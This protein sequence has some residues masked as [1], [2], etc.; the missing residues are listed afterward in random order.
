MAEVREPV[1]GVTP[2]VQ[3]AEESQAGSEGTPARRIF[4]FDLHGDSEQLG[5]KLEPQ[6]AAMQVLVI[7]HVEAPAGN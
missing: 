5:L 4:H 1:A 7:D 6:K 2:A 3:G